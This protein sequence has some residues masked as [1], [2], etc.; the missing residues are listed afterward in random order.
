MTD[1]RQSHVHVD[2][3]EHIRLQFLTAGLGRR[4]AAQL[5]DVLILGLINIVLIL[6][7]ISST[8]ILGD[9]LW[10]EYVVAIGIVMVFFLNGL[11][12][13]LLEYF[14]RGQ[15]VG[16]RMM[17]LRTIQNQGQSMTLL[18]NLLRNFFRIIDFLPLFYFLGAAVMLFHPRDKRIGDLVAGTVVVVETDG[19]RVRKKQKANKILQG[20]DGALPKLILSERTKQ[21]ISHEDWKLLYTYIRRLPTLTEE[22]KRALSARV[23]ERFLEKPGLDEPEKHNGWKRNPEAFLVALY[24][25]LREERE[26]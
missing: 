1:Q 3:P 19:D 8:A 23:M 12:F 4:T 7:L 17:A 16:K 13:V 26:L 9:G 2:T 5:V 25:E 10:S 15:T 11:Y 24:R 20:Y 22:K 18:S 6:A 14:M 21:A